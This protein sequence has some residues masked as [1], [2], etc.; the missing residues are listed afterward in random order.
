MKRLL[1][2]LATFV[3]TLLLVAAILFRQAHRAVVAQEGAE[4]SFFADE[5]LRRM[6]GDL[7]VLAR[8][9]MNR[10]EREYHPRAAVSGRAAAAPARETS[11]SARVRD[12]PNYVLGWM[13][14]GADGSF[15][16]PGAEPATLAPYAAAFRRISGH[17]PGERAQTPQKTSR[18]SYRSSLAKRYFT[19]P[20][21]RAAIEK[22][23]LDGLIESELDAAYRAGVAAGN[24]Q[25]RGSAAR[26]EDSPPLRADF[27]NEAIVFLYNPAV[28]EGAVQYRGVLISVAP[29]LDHLVA[30]YFAGQP[31]ARFTRLELTAR[32]EG[33]SVAAIAV[34]DSSSLGSA[35]NLERPLARPFDFIGARLRADTAPPSPGRATLRVL[36]LVFVAV[37]L[38]GGAALARAVQAQAALAHRRTRFVSSV[39]H[40]LK[41][42]LTVIGMYV[43]MLELGM[44]P[45]AA[46]RERYFGVLKSETARLSRLIHNVLEFS[47]LEARKRRVTVTPGD[48]VPA[49]R[50]AERVMAPQAGRD[51]FDLRVDAPETLEAVFDREAVVQIL[52]NL[53]ENSLKFGAAATR[54]EIVVFAGDTGGGVRFGVRDTGPGI[55]EKALGRIFD[56]FTRGDDPVTL[57][58]KGTGIGLALVRRLALAMGGRAEARNNREAGCTVAV[59]LSGA[60]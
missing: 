30:R 37:A 19:E 22:S 58:T 6:D 43:E 21:L 53:V 51:G 48:I 59:V 13:A 60:G 29:L 42:P 46:T 1:L 40:E 7:A 2:V 32:R 34:G 49:L 45:D 25:T 16:T 15:T 36:I 50:E 3:A 55:G 12:D 56:D 47:Q 27:L 20:D 35:L 26:P 44:A 5:L 52:I 28:A 17:S 4:L 9:V 31:M 38:I 18:G 33:V 54:K 41:T 14:C 24:S 10:D 8:E 39:T 11:T 23:G 57:E